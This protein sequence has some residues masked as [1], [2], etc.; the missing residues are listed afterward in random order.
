M[1][2]VDS[3]ALRDAVFSDVTITEGAPGNFGVLRK[4]LAFTFVTDFF[5]SLCD[6]KVLTGPEEHRGEKKFHQL[7]RKVDSNQPGESNKQR[8]HKNHVTGPI[9]TP[10]IEVELD[11]PLVLKFY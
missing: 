2:N 8:C 3:D 9:D 10:V 11:F 6:G 7:F 1:E 5:K 4:T